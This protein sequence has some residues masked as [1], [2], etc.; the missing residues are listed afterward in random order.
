MKI[1]LIYI[2]LT[3]SY[4]IYLRNDAVEYAKLYYNNIQHKCGKNAEDYKKCTPFAYFGKDFCN[5]ESHDGDCA[6]FVSQCLVHG[7]KHEYLNGTNNC[8]GY[9]CG[10]EEISAKRLGIC[11]QGKGWNSTCGKF[12]EPPIYIKPGDVLIYHGEN[13]D[14]YNAHAVIITSIDPSVKITGRSEVMKDEPYTYNIEKPYYQWLHFIDVD[15]Y[16]KPLESYEYIITIDKVRLG[17]EPCSENYGEYYFYIYAEMNQDIDVSEEIAIDLNTSNNQIIR[18]ICSPHY[19][20]IVQFFLCKI[21]IC[22]Y[23]LNDIDIYLPLDPPIS[24]KYGFLNWKNIIGSSP[25]T[26]NKI[27][28]SK[29]TC[30]PK[31]KNTFIPISIKSE[32]CDGNK[33]IFIINGKWM[34]D[35]DNNQPIFW[36]INLLILNENNKIAYC[37]YNYLKINLKCE[38][39]GYGI[40]KFEETYSKVAYLWKIQEFSS[41]TELTD[42]LSINNG[43]ILLGQSLLNI[44]SLVLLLL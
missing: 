13:C 18:T 33:N 4:S 30:I 20:E 3:F 35:G 29:I 40:I 44:I 36:D 12:M 16:G 34:Y 19:S 10:F 6:N 37:E 23:P 28:N 1:F 7:G 14:S 9:P 24:Q 5:Y 8:R 2:L 31:E 11:L 27:S 42:C 38:Y 43:L 22:E 39:E 15:D 25:G 41:S 26:S 21:D 17:F 32:G